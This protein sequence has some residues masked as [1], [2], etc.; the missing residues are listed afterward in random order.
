ML[1]Q[2]G[3]KDAVLDGHME[4]LCP[5]LAMGNWSASQSAPW[6]APWV[7]EHG[8]QILLSS[9]EEAFSVPIMSG[10]TAQHGYIMGTLALQKPASQHSAKLLKAGPLVVFV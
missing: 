5:R 2:G 10:C 7:W 3:E 1:S 9:M 4:L 8:G 6:A